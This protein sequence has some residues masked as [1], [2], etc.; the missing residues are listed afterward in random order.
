MGKRRSDQC[1][2]TYPKYLLRAPTL[3]DEEADAMSYRVYG[4]F[5]Y[6]RYE[7]GVLFWP[8]SHH[9]LPR[10]SVYE[11]QDL[12]HFPPELRAII[13]E[14]ARPHIFD[15]VLCRKATIAGPMLDDIVTNPCFNKGVMWA[16]IHSL[17]GWADVHTLDID[18][19]YECTQTVTKLI[20]KKMLLIDAIYASWINNPLC[21]G[22]G[23]AQSQ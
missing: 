6:H 7:G 20:H 5:R 8:Y 2:T 21:L 1:F 16:D 14:Y 17:S 23:V 22:G 19:P 18:S 4:G 9:Q 10:I 12:R 15:V 13:W 3:T 11:R